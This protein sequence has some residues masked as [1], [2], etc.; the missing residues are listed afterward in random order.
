MIIDPKA[1][2][3]LHTYAN[4]ASWTQHCSAVANLA[5]YF[6]EIFS[7]KYNV[8]IAFLTSASL[9]HDIGRYRNHDPL[10]HGVEGYR[11]LSNLGFSREAYVCAAHILNGLSTKE[12]V[13]YGLPA[14]DFI[15]RSFEERLI[16]LVDALLESDRPTTLKK[17]FSSLRRRYSDNT[18]FI[19]RLDKAE[20]NVR[21]FM[22]HLNSEFD[23]SMEHVA[24][25]LFGF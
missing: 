15:P 17:R 3:V 14:Q 16:P 13:H 6:G 9:L 20:R 18:F 12:A 10:F 21:S 22:S 2:D 7:I 11:L 19:S 1:Q 24:H 5:A 23:I 25:D 8:D 4:G